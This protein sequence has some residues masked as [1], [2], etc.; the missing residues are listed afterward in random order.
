MCKGQYTI[1]SVDHVERA[2]EIEMAQRDA[3][4]AGKKGGGSE[5]SVMPKGA[6]STAGLKIESE[7][8]KNRNL[9]NRRVK[10]K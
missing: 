8:V 3:K 4:G 1:G 7:E 6:N 2:K 10:E 9:R 5:S